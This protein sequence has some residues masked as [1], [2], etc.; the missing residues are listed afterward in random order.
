QLDIEQWN[1]E[2]ILKKN[3]RGLRTEKLEQ[4]DKLRARRLITGVN[5]AEDLMLALGYSK[6]T[7]QTYGFENK[8]DTLM[9]KLFDGMSFEEAKLFYTSNFLGDL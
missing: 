1:V 4:F 8:I 2:R 9:Q 7:V 3:M 6:N 5:T